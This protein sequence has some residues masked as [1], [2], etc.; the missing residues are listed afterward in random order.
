MYKEIKSPEIEQVGDSFGIFL[1]GTIDGGKAVD[2]Q[3]EMSVTLSTIYSN[4]KDRSVV[5]YNPRRDAWDPSWAADMSEPKFREQVGWEAEHMDDCDLVVMNLLG[6][7]DS[8]ISM[9][10][11]GLLAKEE[12]MVYV[13][14]MRDDFVERGWKN[15]ARCTGSDF[16]KKIIVLCSD[17]FRRKGNVDFICER[18]SILQARDEAQLIEMIEAHVEEFY[19]KEIKCKECGTMTHTPFGGDYCSE[20]CEKKYL[21]YLNK[22]L[23]DDEHLDTSASITDW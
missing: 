2:W 9:L 6:G 17:E 18:H 3:R 20:V 1:A 22:G 5:V 11:L 23:N 10:E 13:P 15:A 21:A 12:P 14:R 8:I 7:S 4:R 19:Y 16:P